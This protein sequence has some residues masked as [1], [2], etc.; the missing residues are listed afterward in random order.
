MFPTHTYGITL[1]TF[2]VMSLDY[3]KALHIIFVVTW[4]AGL[5]YIVRLFIY[6]REAAEKDEPE[7]GILVNQF[8]IMQKRL[9]FGITWPSAILASVFG[10]WMLLANFGPYIAQPW[11]ILK[12]IFV[13][14]LW[15]YQIQCHVIFSQQKKD[16][17]KFSSIKLRL[18]NEVATLFLFAIVF[19]VVVKS[20]GSLVWGAL[21]LIL[22][23]G[24]IFLAVFI[25]K[26]QRE[27]KQIEPGSS[28]KITP[29]PANQ[30]E[31]P[32]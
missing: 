26:K 16:I 1:P 10:T 11:M 17:Y 15:L 25:Y 4:F 30:D 6:Q 21:G 20:S 13:G 32:L 2:A 18:F 14:G 5:F 7:K 8:R 27:K 3:V 23:S 24:F 31:S 12:L 28:D 19:L 22:L 9:W 29:P